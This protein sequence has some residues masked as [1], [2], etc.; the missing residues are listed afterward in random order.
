MLVNDKTLTL[1]QN[2]AIDMANFS[3]TNDEYTDLI[4]NSTGSS[5]TS[6]AADEWKSTTATAVDNIVLTGNGDIKIGGSLTSTFGGVKIDSASGKVYS[7]G[8]TLGD[9]ITITGTSNQTTSTGVDLPYDATK[10]AAIVIIS[11]D[12]LNL[13]AST[14]LSAGGTYNTTNNDNAGVYFTGGDPIDVAI[15]LASTGAG[16]NVAVDSKVTTIGPNGAMVIDAKEKVTFGDTFK[17]FSAFD[18]TNWLE[19]VSRIAGIDLNQTISQQI[20]PSADNLPGL[21]FPGT[22]ILRG[23]SPAKVLALMTTTTKPVPLVPPIALELKDRGEIEGVD[24]EALLLQWGAEEFGQGNV[25]S[26]LEGA[27]LHSTD[28]RPYEALRKLKKLVEEILIDKGGQSQAALVEIVA[29]HVKEGS[30]P[31]EEQICLIA[32]ELKNNEAVWQWL[33]AFTDYMVILN[34]EI[35]MTAEGSV[36]LAMEKYGPEDMRG[37]LFIQMCLESSIGKDGCLCPQRD[38]NLFSDLHLLSFYTSRV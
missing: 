37:K 24:T 35:G 22:Y 17:D 5:V 20:L 18:T 14:T 29:K 19:A 27:Y 32:V 25:Q 3:V 23:D 6:A 30:Q 28:L 31:T 1:T 7:S 16:T 8:S 2:D 34:T 15:Y 21:G 9:G 36:K 12:D 13:G 4:A 33:K 10:K 26:Y 11:K 38:E